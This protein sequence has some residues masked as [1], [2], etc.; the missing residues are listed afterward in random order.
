MSP[1]KYAVESST[2]V[3]STAEPLTPVRTTAEPTTLA[4]CT[5]YDRVHKIQSSFR[6]LCAVILTHLALL[7]TDELWEVVQ[8]VQMGEVIA[9]LP[10]GLEEHVAEGGENFSQGQRQ[11][12]CIGRKFSGVVCCLSSC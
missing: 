12:L 2:P 9:A 11:L 6:I 10:G 7:L 5:S 4:R 3:P 8:K 1:T